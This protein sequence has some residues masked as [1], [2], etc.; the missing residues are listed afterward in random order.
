MVEAFN[1]PNSVFAEHEDP[2]VGQGLEAGDV[3]Q[4]VVIQVQEHQAG[5]ELQVVDLLDEVVLETE[6]AEARLLREDWDAME[7]PSVKIDP[8]RIL[9]PLLLSPLH[10]H[11]FL[12]CHKS[13][14]RI[15]DGRFEFG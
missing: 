10:P 8:V 5:D 3:I 4:S 12:L 9:G 2:E 14:I 6:Q 15:S 13:A 7:T 1:F 11:N